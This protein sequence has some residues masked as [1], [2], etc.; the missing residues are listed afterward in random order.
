MSYHYHRDQSRP[1]R[2]SPDRTL[3][4]RSPPQRNPSTWRPE[5]TGETCKETGPTCEE[6]GPILCQKV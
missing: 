1:D 6:T 4:T 2:V 3:Y 5:M